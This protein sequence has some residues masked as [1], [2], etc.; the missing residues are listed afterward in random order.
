LQEI[1]RLQND[2]DRMTEMA[3]GRIVGLQVRLTGKTNIIEA[4]IAEEQE[5]RRFP[6]EGQLGEAYA[7]AFDLRKHLQALHREIDRLDS[8]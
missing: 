4:R 3:I 7:R 8:I 1:E 6:S 2:A 5:G